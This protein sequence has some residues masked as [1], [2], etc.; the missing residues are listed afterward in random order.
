MRKPACLLSR[1]THHQLR[2]LFCSAVS[3]CPRVSGLK[4]GYHRPW[5]RLGCQ[6]DFAMVGS[7]CHIDSLQAHAGD[8]TATV[9]LALGP[10][11]SGKVTTVRKSMAQL[12]IG[13]KVQ[14]GR[15]H[16]VASA[17]RQYRC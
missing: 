8:A 6:A 17:I 14:A 5:L 16:C 7:R 11:G 12:E 13:D 3:R 15:P 2:S 10:A 9:Q 1:C 4:P